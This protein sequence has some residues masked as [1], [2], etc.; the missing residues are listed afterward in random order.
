MSPGAARRRK[1][2]T[3]L[4]VVVLGAG[5]TACSDTGKI[6]STG[7]VSVAP[8][9]AAPATTTTTTGA[10]PTAGASTT[11]VPGAVVPADDEASYVS[12]TSSAMEFRGEDGRRIAYACPPDGKVSEITGVGPFTDDSSV[13]SAGVFE[14]A[15]TAKAGGRVVI[16]IAAGRDGYA[17]GT[18]HGVTA[19]DFGVWAG[20][21]TVVVGGPQ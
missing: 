10:A 8:T 14:G 5:A 19:T 13:C 20:S 12:W 2:A 18:A 3:L 17:A 21:F 7:S 15:I 6:T 4:L 11:S 16:E 9:T 1:A